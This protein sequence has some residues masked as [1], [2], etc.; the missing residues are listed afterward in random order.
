MLL[1][2]LNPACF[3]LSTLSLL[4]EE[5][6]EDV[7]GGVDRKENKRVNTAGDRGNEGRVIIV[8]ESHKTEDDVFRARDEGGQSGEGDD[9]GVWRGNE[10]E[11]TTEE[12]VNGGDPGGNGSGRAERSGEE[13]E[14]VQDADY[15]GRYRIQRIDDTR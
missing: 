4:E 14:R 7:D 5:G 3:S 12:K 13:P 2:R 6:Y 9:V 8:T 11:E 10:E 1:P 15:D